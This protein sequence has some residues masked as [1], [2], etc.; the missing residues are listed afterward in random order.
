M[1]H[2]DPAVS[3]TGEAK[4]RRRQRRVWLAITAP[5]LCALAILLIA[6]EAIGPS[7]SATPVSPLFALIFSFVLPVAV[8]IGAIMHHRV[9][10]EQEE[11]AILW[12]NTVGFYAAIVSVM[13]ADVLAMSKIMPLI[14]HVVMLVPAFGAAVLTYVWVKYR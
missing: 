6:R 11:R 13:I 14:S 7:A 4:A 8:V 1:I 3:G 9:I 10:D 5:A 2:D 12:G